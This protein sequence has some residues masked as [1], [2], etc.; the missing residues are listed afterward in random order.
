[1]DRKVKKKMKKIILV[2]APWPMFNRPS[3]QLGTLKAW[4]TSR[5]PDIDVKASH[6]YLEL[7]ASIGY[8]LYSAV[9]ERSWSA[10]S[11]YAALLYP[12]RFPEVEKIFRKET[13]RRPMLRQVDFAELTEMVKNVSDSFVESIDWNAFGLAGFSICLCQLTS[14]IFFIRAVRKTAPDLPIVV[15]GSGIAGGSEQDLLKVFPEIDFAVNGEGEIPLSRLIET[16]MHSSDLSNLSKISGVASRH[17]VGAKQGP[18]C[19]QVPRLDD[20]P[21]PDYGDYFQLLNSFSGEK[22]FFP[23]LPL[24]LSRGCWW[25]KS[26]GVRK[27]SGCAFCNLNL[28]WEGYRTKTSRRAVVE[29]DE[30]TS[31]YQTLSVAF[32]DNLLPV[33][34]SEEIF[35]LA[36]RLEKDLKLFGE[37]RAATPERT[38]K[39]MHGAGMS[40]VQI[41]IEAL[42][43]RLLKKLNKG[44]TVIQN[45]AIMK[46]CE[47]MGLVNASNLILQFPGSDRQDVTETLHS[48][49]FVLPFRP[50]RFV[51][52]WLGLGSPVWQYPGNYGIRAVFNHPY[53]ARLFPPPLSRAAR[54]MIQAYRGDLTYQRKLWLPVKEKVRSWKRSYAE[55]HA[56]PTVHPILSYRDGGDFMIIRQR[57]PRTDAM[58]HRLTG[59]SRAIYLFCRR[60]RSLKSIVSRFPEPGEEKITPFL[61]M[62]VDKKLMF[63]ENG[64]Y[65]SLAVQVSR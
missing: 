14:T 18:G 13:A 36:G 1:M 57:Q 65:L 44:T 56:G 8:P 21:Q 24:E 61:K 12:E 49:S 27:T 28:Q 32:M 38:L 63:E 31:H 11:V 34:Q 62:L 46:A 42:S 9:C 64:R 23:T 54:F 48:L 35:S 5:F 22:A 58:T 47:E 2:S 51:H 19:V 16:L 55:L 20:L 60:H 41:G 43:T 4:L 45:L 40:E 25:K 52:F 6:F 30:M 53:Y 33:R 37:I 3:I 59:T 7:A 17:S 15:G 10:E 39:A 26:G 29:I 50:L